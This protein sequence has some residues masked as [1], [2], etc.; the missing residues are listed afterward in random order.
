MKG[1]LLL[2]QQDI[3]RFRVARLAHCSGDVIQ[4]GKTH[5]PHDSKVNAT[6]LAK[7]FQHSE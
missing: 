5:K 7:Q 2:T 4:N 1:E 6:G 3:T